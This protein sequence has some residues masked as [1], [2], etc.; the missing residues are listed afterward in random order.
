[1]SAVN[2]YNVGLR[3]SVEDGGPYGFLHVILG[4][5]FSGKSSNLIRHYRRHQIAK[6]NCLLVKYQ[7]DT[8]YDGNGNENGKGNGNGKENGNGD[9]L[10]QVCGGSGLGS[11]NEEQVEGILRTHDR[12]E[13]RSA[14]VTDRLAHL[15]SVVNNYDVICIDE[16]QFYEDNVEWCRRLVQ[17]GK[18]VIVCGLFAD[19]RRIPFKGIPELIAMSDCPEFLT[20]ICHDCYMDNATVSHRLTSDTSQVLIGGA[21]MYVPLCQMCFEKRN[22][23]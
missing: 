16:I 9:G 8:R 6:R 17:M 11:L 2:S 22:N 21:E 7:G 13:G 4:C 5:M 19:F 3:N 20:A 14:F 10:G 23:T 1:M 15:E 12:I 18:I